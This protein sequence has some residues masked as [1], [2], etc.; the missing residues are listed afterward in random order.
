MT[1]QIGFDVDAVA[2]SIAAG[3]LDAFGDLLADDVEWR[4]IDQ[5][6]PPAAPAVVRGREAVLA[7]LRDAHDARGI[8]TEVADGF[9]AGDRAALQ[10][11]CSYPSGEQ[12]VCNALLLIRDGRIARFS[13]V[14]A[15]DG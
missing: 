5:R 10:L 4:E 11:V 6:T 1:V 12:V 9:V 14:Q 8:T 2:R 13:G 3:D 15:W 7:N